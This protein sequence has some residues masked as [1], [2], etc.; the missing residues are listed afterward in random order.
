MEKDMPMRCFVCDCPADLRQGMCSYHFD[1]CYGQMAQG[2]AKHSQTS[3]LKLKTTVCEQIGGA[4]C[5]GYGSFKGHGKAHVETFPAVAN[6]T[7]H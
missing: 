5:E 6:P 7:G 4:T 3:D 1:N 2:V